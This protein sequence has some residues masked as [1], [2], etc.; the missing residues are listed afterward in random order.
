VGEE[1]SGAEGVRRGALSERL[2]GEGPIA[3]DLLLIALH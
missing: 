3:D 1:E 2:V